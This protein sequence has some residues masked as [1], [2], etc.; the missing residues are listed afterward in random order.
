MVFVAV[1]STSEADWPA[2]WDGGS[3][4][5][6]LADAQCE[7]SAAVARPV[8]PLD[9]SQALSGW[10]D[11]VALGDM[12]ACPPMAQAQDWEFGLNCASVLCCTASFPEGIPA[13]PTTCAKR[14]AGSITPP[15][16]R[17]AAVGRLRPC[18]HD[19][20]IASWDVG[21]GYS[22]KSLSQCR[23]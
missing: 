18:E 22:E 5:L 7:R 14:G 10:L 17:P 11:A 12:Q 20:L 21:A 23:R 8:P 15:T 6:I 3:H 2:D 4:V 9:L 1:L 19:M 13:A 16:S